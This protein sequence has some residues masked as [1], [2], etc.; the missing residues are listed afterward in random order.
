MTKNYAHRGYCA[1]YP[2]NTML[3]F[4]K[5]IEVGCDGIELDIHL[6]KD[7]R[8]VIIHDEDLARTT[9]GRGFVKDKTLE[10]LKKLDAGLGETIPTIEEYFALVCDLDIVTN[11]ELK[12]SI[13]PYPNMEQLLIAAVRNRKL[14]SRV[15]L[16]SFNHE[17]MR[18]CKFLA[19]DIRCGLLYDCRLINGGNYAHQYGIEYLHPNYQNLTDDNLCEMRRQN[20]G[21]NVWNVNSHDEMESMLKMGVD[22]I[23]TNDPLLL[24]EVM[25]V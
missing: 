4:A 25:A 18:L 21:V 20:V 22:G 16:S 10:E 1:R 3:A 23:I 7:S 24:R 2:E 6:T 12:N 19:P 15:I 17:S 11:I 13:F 9:G 8:L 14:E 5:A